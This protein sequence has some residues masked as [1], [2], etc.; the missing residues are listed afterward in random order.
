MTFKTA[1][2][3]LISD[4]VFL[5]WKEKNKNSFLSYGFTSLEQDKQSEWQIGYYNKDTDKITS[6]TFKDNKP[7]IGQEEEIFKEP[8]A[9]ILELEL[10]K[11]KITLD[12]ALDLADALQKE[13]YPN[14]ESIK[15][16]VILQNIE[17]FG[18]IWNITY[19][20]KSFNVLNIKLSALDGKIIKHKLSSLTDF[21]RK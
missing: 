5:E 15:T 16:I 20:A 19:I 12:H 11:V 8:N 13:K 21:K 1:M 3:K 14:Q 10:D 4:K 7:V 9:K 18:T 17:D 2:E 6:F